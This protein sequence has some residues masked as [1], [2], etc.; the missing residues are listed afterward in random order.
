[1]K[2]PL[3]S[4]VVL[5]FTLTFGLSTAI[6]QV[7]DCPHCKGTTAS[8]LVHSARH[9]DEKFIWAYSK[10]KWKAYRM[11]T[12]KAPYPGDCPPR[13]YYPWRGIIL[14]LACKLHGWHA[15]TGMP[16]HAWWSLSQSHA[17][18]GCPSCSPGS[19]IPLGAQPLMG[20]APYA[21]AMPVEV[22]PAQ[23]AIRSVGHHDLLSR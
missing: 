14:W 19:A 15:T 4:T 2:R 9:L 17:P 23:G 3:L 5:G 11:L 22:R 21:T 13:P 6:A 7:G 12:V 16:S 18:A 20:P 1:M 10:L 8:M